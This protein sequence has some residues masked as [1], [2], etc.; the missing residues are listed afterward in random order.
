[1]K[2][3]FLF[4]VYS[5]LGWVLETVLIT[6]KQKQIVNCGFLNGP[7]C[8]IYGITAV[9]LTMSLTT[10]DDNLFFLFFGSVIY[11]TVIELLAGKFLE[12]FYHGRWW[13]YSHKRWNFDGY[14]CV[15]HSAF[16]GL[17]GVIVIKWLNPFF[18]KI[19]QMPPRLLI[20]TILWALFGVLAADILG[21]TA[22]LSGRKEQAARYDRS[23]RKLSQIR[24]A[25]QARIRA[26]VER[27]ITRAYPLSAKAGRTE[28]KSGVFAEGCGFYKLF[29]LFF[30]GAFIGDLVE[31]LF[32]R[33]TLGWWMSRS[34]V[35]WGPFSIV[36]GLALA[37][38]T[39]LLY[40]HRNRAD[41]FLFIIGTLVGG[42]FEYLCSVFTEQVF[43]TIFWDY[44]SVPFNLAGRI[45]LLYCFFWGIAAVVW[46]RLI[47]GKIS[48]LIERIPMRVGKPLTWI[49]VVFMVCNVLVSSLALGRYQE[50]RAGVKAEKTW[51]KAMDEYFDDDVMKRIY[52]KAKGLEKRGI[53]AEQ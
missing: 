1:M 14:V 33:V 9:V 12:K 26:A 34:S 45:N 13:D 42:A 23:N 32:C 48:G 6:L 4:F 51:Q 10:L 15:S 8:M 46:F 21:T 53:P 49:L 17:L 52:P 24:I 28:E 2:F 38:F 36:W 19:Y 3:L 5:F 35:V 25:L 22:V 18:T 20:H 43:G 30:V 50:R 41:S 40:Q 37:I 16:W 11:A 31:T 27:R 47:Y 39:A 7:V 44:S 29:W